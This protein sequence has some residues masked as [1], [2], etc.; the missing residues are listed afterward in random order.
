MRIT[1]LN[2]TGH[3][4][5]TTEPLTEIETRTEQIRNM[6]PE[7]LEKEFNNLIKEGYT[8]VDEKTNKIMERFDDKVENIRMLYPTIRG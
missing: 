1:I 6:S 5:L 7:E 8:A 3:E 4:V 2:K